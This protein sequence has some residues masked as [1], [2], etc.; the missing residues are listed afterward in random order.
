MALSAFDVAQ[1]QFDEAAEAMGLDHAMREVLRVPQRELIVNFPVRMDNG[2]VRVFT[3]FRVQ[4]NITR[5]PAKGGLRYHPAV[6]LDE[7][8][9]LAMW[10]S[11]KTALMHIPFG[12]A[13]GGIICDPRRLSQGELERMTRR[14]A[15]EI[16]LLVGPH[17]DIPA[18]DVGTTAQTMA[19]FMDTISMHQGFSMPAVI[20]GKPVSVGGSE[21]RAEATGRGVATVTVRALKTLGIAPADA[22][23]TVQGCGNVGSVSAMLLERAGCKV[24]G[25]C[26]VDGAIWNPN[27]L[28]IPALLEHVRE[29]G[30]VLGFAGGSDAPG[31]EI[32]TANTTVVVPA[33]LE[34]QITPE[35]AAQMRCKVVVEGAN[36]P[37]TP[38][39]DNVL[40][41]RGILLVPDILANAGGVVVSYFEWV[42]DLQAFF[43]EE[44]DINLR[45]ENLMRRA[46]DKV[47]GIAEVQ[48]ITMRQAAYS[49]AV[50]KVAQ[51]TL[52]RGIY[53]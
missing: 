32:L 29:S 3:G 44:S 50:D 22:T 26:D 4:H 6:N 14:F 30:G 28:H 38:D 46:F 43:W 9:A 39:A 7:V 37:T 45:L 1:R 31:E 20:T 49:L 12:G 24:I 11:W 23:V 5:G 35:V 16:S 13:K 47:H 41:D 2:T 36:G 8:K 40:R 53:P 18:P 48:G 15:T 17:S 10:M 34:G 27:G 33:A 21:G 42:Q 19:W 52:V 25:I 51:A